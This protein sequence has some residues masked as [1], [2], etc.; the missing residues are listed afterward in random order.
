MRLLGIDFGF[1]R[2]GV[3]IGESE[4]GIVTPRSAIAASGGLKA[5]AKTIAALARK[6]EVKAIV[7]GLP[8][9]ETGN[10]GRMARICRT[11]AQHLTDLGET[12]HL[13]DEKYSSIEAEQVL[14]EAGLKPSQWK[15]HKD[16]EAAGLILER[17]FNGEATQ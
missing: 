16:S 11:L 9:E 3:A 12:V 10:E 2:I 15:E 13:V 1:K 14:A 5:D 8:V 4:V 17:Y 6:E 7:L